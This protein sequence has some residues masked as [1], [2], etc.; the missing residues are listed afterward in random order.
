[1]LN[2]R[3]RLTYSLFL[4]STFSLLLYLF[5]HFDDSFHLNLDPYDPFKPVSESVLSPSIAQNDIK[6]KFVFLKD[7]FNTKFHHFVPNLMPLRSVFF[8]NFVSFQ[9]LLDNDSRLEVEY[10]KFF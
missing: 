3:S 10:G 5:K 6:I 1:M 9:V 8:G 4:A 2:L 7:F